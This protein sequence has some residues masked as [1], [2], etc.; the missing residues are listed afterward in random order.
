MMTDSASK[1]RIVKVIGGGL[2][3][4]EAAYKLSRFG[5]KVILYEQRPLVNN[6]I[7]RTDLLAE[8]VCSNSLKSQ[9]LADASGLLKLEL[10]ILGSIVVQIANR[11]KIPAGKALAVEREP[12][13]RKITDIILQ[14]PNIELIRKEIKKL[15]EGP[16][17]I[18][19]GPLTSGDL[20]EELKG[21]LGKEFLYYYDAVAPIISADSI[22][23]SKAFWDSRY[24][25]KDDY[26][27]L[28]LT[29][30]EYDIFYEALTKADQ[31]DWK[32]P[33][34]DIRYFEGCLP[35]E[36]LARRGK[37]TLLFGPMSPKGLK[38]APKGTYAVIQLR[39][40]NLPTDAFSIVGFQT[41]LRW[42]DQKKVLSLI[43]ALR[44][45]E[46]I[47]YGVMHRNTYI[48]SP[49][50]LE[51]TLK[52]KTSPEDNPIFFAG[53]ITG[54]EGYIEAAA[55]GIIAAINLANLLRKKK[56]FIP[57]KTTAIGSL[58][59]YVS[60][61]EPKSF[62]PMSANFGLI[63]RTEQKQLQASIKKLRELISRFKISIEDRS[64]IDESANK[65]E[66]K[67]VRGQRLSKREEK[68]A[69]SLKAIYDLISYILD[70]HPYLLDLDLKDID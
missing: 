1:D 58:L 7:H 43:P 64:R 32:H 8:L 4:V 40:E 17:I 66:E 5:F 49:L 11:Y 24:T 59:R 6:G 37:K 39:R 22:D 67:M 55:G 62:V 60:S 23:Y 47:R 70:E 44:N 14:D 33:E 15:P 50:L 27:N 45:V 51:P 38:K 29:E 20:S 9:E 54:T 18:A 36:E 52:L 10:S 34:E 3:G 53:Q 69:R 28:P 57:P 19:T 13:S 63:P 25:G 16:I 26:L 21:L 35:I 31:A 12:F 42:Q 2:A 30:E 68:E 65:I 48:L 46:F 41:R 61:T 56:P